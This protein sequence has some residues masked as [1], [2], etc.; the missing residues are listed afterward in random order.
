VGAQ[1]ERHRAVGEELAVEV[2][3]P[4]LHA[5]KRGVLRD[6]VA[7]LSRADRFGSTMSE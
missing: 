3:L 2:E 5:A 7:E 4:V 1:F 6:D